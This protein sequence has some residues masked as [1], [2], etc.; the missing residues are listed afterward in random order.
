MEFRDFSNMDGEV[1]N[2]DVVMPMN[3]MKGNPYDEDNF[4]SQA[5][6][7]SEF[8]QAIG[9]RKSS[10]K[11][12]GGGMF[13]GTILDK[14]ERSRRRTLRENTRAMRQDRRNLG[15]ESRANAKAG[16]TDA[17]LSQAETQ[18]QVAATLGNETESDKAIAAALAKS[19]TETTD[20]PGMSTAVKISIGVGA[21]LLVGGIIAFVV[22]KNKSKKGK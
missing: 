6:G 21:L 13:S 11:K 1:L 2:Y 10:K 22:Y 18:R 17:K 5:D 8:S 12:R 20:K 9:R 4:Y 19:A 14:N 15:A 16:R 7:D 3:A